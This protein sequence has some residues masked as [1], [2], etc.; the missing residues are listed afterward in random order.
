MKTYKIQYYDDKNSSWVGYNDSLG[1]DVSLFKAF[2]ILNC[3]F[4]MLAII[5]MNRVMRN[6]FHMQKSKAQIS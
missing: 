6:H 2:F 4:R 3:F 5:I 1:Q